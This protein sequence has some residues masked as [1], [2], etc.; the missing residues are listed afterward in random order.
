MKFLPEFV[1]C[2]VPVSVSRMEN[3]EATEAPGAEEIRSLA[4][5]TTRIHLRRRRGAPYTSAAKMAGD[6]TPSL[7][8]ISEDNVVLVV[9]ERKKSEDRTAESERSVKRKSGSR[10]GKARGV[11]GRNN[12]NDFRRSP[13]AIPVVIPAFSPTPFLF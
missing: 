3:P 6:W 13:A 7:G 2:C 5:V 4:P 9:M 8:A 1:S 11:H 10:N 12:S